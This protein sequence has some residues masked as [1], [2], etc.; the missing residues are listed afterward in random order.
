MR[1]RLKMAEIEL[2]GVVGIRMKF[3]R[4]PISFVFIRSS[5]SYEF[6]VFSLFPNPLMVS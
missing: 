4:F 6:S 1:E 2:Y 5:N 3:G